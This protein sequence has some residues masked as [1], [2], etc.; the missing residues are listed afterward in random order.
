MYLHNINPKVKEQLVKLKSIN[1][2]SNTVGQ[3]TVE[4]MCNPPV[5]DVSEETKNLYLKEYDALFA[6]L[7]KR[8]LLVT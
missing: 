8:A 3:A 6:S 2:C 5:K 4:L 7:K 1:L